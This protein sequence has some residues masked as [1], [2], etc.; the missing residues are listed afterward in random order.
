MGEEVR[1]KITLEQWKSL[2]VRAI[3]GDIRDFYRWIRII[4]SHY[5]DF[6][7]TNQ[8][9]LSYFF[10]NVTFG[11]F[12][13]FHTYLEQ[14]FISDEN[15]T[16]WNHHILKLRETGCILCVLKPIDGSFPPTNLSPIQVDFL[17]VWSG[18]RDFTKKTHGV[19]FTL[20]R[21]I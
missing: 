8:Y 18:G 2:F 3:L 20:F 6:L 16:P 15:S 5:K 4:P 9:F 11:F 10:L 13:I 21:L 19:Y 12:H 7:S 17:E 1:H 14:V